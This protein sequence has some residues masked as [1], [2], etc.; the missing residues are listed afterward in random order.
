MQEIDGQYKLWNLAF[1]DSKMMK[2]LL[3]LDTTMFQEHCFLT[4]DLSVLI[5]LWECNEFQQP[6]T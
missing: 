1:D 3:W 4:K 2:N 6:F 5:T